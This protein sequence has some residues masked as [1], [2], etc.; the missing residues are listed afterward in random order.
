MKQDKNRPQGVPFYSIKSGDTHF[1]RSSAQIQAYINSSDMGVNAS[2]D[3]DFGWRLHADWVKK[4]KEFRRD[5]NK[6]EALSRKFGGRKI[7]DAQILMAIY[8]AQMRVYEQSKEDTDAP[9]EEEY[10]RSISGGG[11]STPVAKAPAPM[12]EV[13][14]EQPKTVGVDPAK[15]G[16]DKTVEAPVPEEPKEEVKDG[17]TNT[18]TDSTESA[19]EPVQE[20]PTAS[21]SDKPADKTEKSKSQQ[22]R[23]AELKKTAAKK[24]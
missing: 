9:F 22:R 10:L 23:E 16:E 24:S 4:T 2:R 13:P 17:D 3:Q 6:M 18:S 8:R 12:P 15:P 1:A 7:T 21:D 19:T 14:T 11:Q 5:E 20:E